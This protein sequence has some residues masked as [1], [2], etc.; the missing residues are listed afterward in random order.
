MDTRALGLVVLALG[1]GRRRASDSIDPRVGLSHVLPLGTRVQSGQ[2]LLRVH[3]AS[4]AD[5]GAAL[6][7]LGAALHIGD[8]MREQPAPVLHGWVE[9]PD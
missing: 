4:T 8:A 6:A 9:T 3:A 7:S 5:A 2:P 1:G